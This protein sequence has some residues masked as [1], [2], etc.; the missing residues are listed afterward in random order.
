MKVLRLFLLVLLITPLFAA[1]PGQGRLVMIDP[2]HGGFDIGAKVGKVQEKVLSLKTAN[3]VKKQ[4]TKLGY[5]VV[6]TRTRD[7]SIPLKKRTQLA[8]DTKSQ[9]FVSIHYNAHEVTTVHGIEIFY[10]NRGS[11]W[12]S[13]NSKKVAELIL[14]R[15]IKSTGAKSRGVKHGNFH[16]IRETGMPAILVEGGFVTNPEERAR[17]EKDGYIEKIARAITDGVNKHFN[18]R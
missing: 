12:R 14:N 1:A 15:M 10:Y 18:P 5:R 4:L 7:V 9:L 16:V 11:K 6:L 13:Q 8:N 3:L 17:L 2:G